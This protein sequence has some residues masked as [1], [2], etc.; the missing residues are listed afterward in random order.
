MEEPPVWG[1]SRSSGGHVGSFWPV[2]SP[3][4]KFHMDA[5]MTDPYM[6]FLHICVYH[7]QFLENLVQSLVSTADKKEVHGS[8][9]LLIFIIRGT[10][11]I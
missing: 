2:R 3:L 4:C 9:K 5:K 11:M 7:T 6:F 1:I 10:G 8:K